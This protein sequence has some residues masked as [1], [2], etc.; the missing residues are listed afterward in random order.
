HAEASRSRA[1][2]RARARRTPAAPRRSSASA[3]DDDAAAETEPPVADVVDPR[4]PPQIEEPIERIPRPE[5]ANARAEKA[6]DL[7]PAGRDEGAEARK[8]DADVQLP[9]RTG[10]P[11]YGELQHPDRA[12]GAD[13]PGELAQ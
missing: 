2:R 13:D 12:S 10:E 1:S 8:A 9:S 6:A 4:G 5:A 7:G 11:G 3:P